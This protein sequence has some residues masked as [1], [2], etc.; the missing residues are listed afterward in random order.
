M[1]AWLRGVLLTMKRQR[2]SSF[3]DRRA[4][5]LSGDTRDKLALLHIGWLPRLVRAD[6]DVKRSR[7]GLFPQAGQP[8]ER[9]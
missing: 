9:S 7:R 1:T 8:N 6:V 5:Y 3:A 4:S 2:A